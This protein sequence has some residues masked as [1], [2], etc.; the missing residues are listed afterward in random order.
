MIF[1]LSRPVSYQDRLYDRI[2][3]TYYLD[4]KDK[5][6]AQQLASLEVGKVYKLEEV[7]QK[8]TLSQIGYAWSVM[9]Q[10]ASDE[11][12]R[13]DGLTADDIYREYVRRFGK[14]EVKAYPTEIAKDYMDLWVQQGTGTT[15]GW[16]TEVINEYDGMTEFVCYSGMSSWNKKELSNFIDHLLDDCKDQGIYITKYY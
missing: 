13:R 5:E 3:V 2:A 6:M 11:H 7:A 12:Y 4:P 15:S 10:M 8:K 9:H 14:Y 1:R 16:Q